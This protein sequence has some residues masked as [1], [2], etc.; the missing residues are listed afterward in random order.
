MPWWLPLD[1]VVVTT[2]QPDRVLNNTA[3]SSHIHTTFEGR[4][5]K[6]TKQK[7]FLEWSGDHS[8]SSDLNPG[9]S[10]I[11][12]RLGPAANANATGQSVCGLRDFTDRPNV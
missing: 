6:L 7:A 8:E 10:C 11:L 1:A 3:I 9:L 5:K 4:K 12:A 2:H